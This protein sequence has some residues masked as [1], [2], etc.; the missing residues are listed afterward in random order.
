MVACGHP[1]GAGLVCDVDTPSY[2]Q[3][4]PDLLSDAYYKALI[5]SSEKSDMKVWFL[6]YL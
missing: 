3:S 5:E 4:H 1:C 2:L 6:H